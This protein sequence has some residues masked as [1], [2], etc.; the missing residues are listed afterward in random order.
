M[1]PLRED[2]DPV[3]QLRAVMLGAQRF[4]QAMADH[5]GLSLSEM[6]LLGHLSDAGGQLTPREVTRRMLMG[7]GTVTAIIDRLVR[8]GYAIRNPHAT[9][10]RS[11]QVALTPAGR[12]VTKF[13]HRH[14]SHALT[15]AGAEGDEVG[16]SNLR[17]A[18]EAETDRVLRRPRPTKELR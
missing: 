9:D 3:A 7:S 10:R 15:A 6:V 12:K 2:A 5:L 17:V 18:L 4:R 13:V 14:I 1:D 8:T 16:L 11:V